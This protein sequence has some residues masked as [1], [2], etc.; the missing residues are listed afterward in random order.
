MLQ[1]IVI[2]LLAFAAL[3]VV[4]RLDADSADVTE[5]IVASSP[6]PITHYTIKQDSPGLPRGFEPLPVPLTLPVEEE[7]SK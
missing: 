6:R 4:G 1:E 5:R 2:L 7:T 3:C